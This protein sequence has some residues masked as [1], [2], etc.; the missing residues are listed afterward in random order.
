MKKTRIATICAALAAVVVA[1][2]V[3]YGG[4]EA[5]DTDMP[6]LVSYVDSYDGAIIIE[7]DEVPLAAKPVVKTKTTTKK[8]VKRTK[9]KTKSKKSS[10]KTTTKTTVKNATKTSKTQK[11]QTQTTTKTTQ[12]T[13]LKKKSNIKTVTTTVKTTVK[14]TTTPI[15]QK[16]AAKKTQPVK[17]TATKKNV[18]IRTIAPKA[19]E[20]VKKAFETLNFKVLVN[21]AVNYSGKFDAA[22]Q[23]ITV[24][25]NS[26]E[27]IYHELGHFVAFLAGN[28]DTKSEFVNI[29]KSEISKF[30]GTRNN[31]SYIKSTSAEYFA[32]SYQDYIERPSE[33]KSQRPKTYNYIKDCV[34]KI[35]DSK[36]KLIKQLYASKW[37]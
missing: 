6:Q 33:L 34:N 12:Q 32:E 16:A 21:P 29:Y 18:A 31:D 19:H 17:T 7:E 11:V 25:T 5:A 27:A 35:T 23:L 8:T 13:V 37:N 2:G 4:K 20:N 24:H 14:T 30:K 26:D 9:M 3:W 10:T 36:V 1:G 22:T 15:A 28:A